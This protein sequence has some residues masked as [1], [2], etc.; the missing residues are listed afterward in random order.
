MEAGGRYLMELYQ[1]SSDKASI[2]KL[3]FDVL[4]VGKTII[5]TENPIT[6]VNLV[7]DIPRE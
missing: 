5:L 1:L 2:L 6:R 3:G 4:N 7:Y